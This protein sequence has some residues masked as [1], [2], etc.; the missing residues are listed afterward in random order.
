MPVCRYPSS[1]RGRGTA[2]PF[3]RPRGGGLQLCRIVL[4]DMWRLVYSAVE[5]VT[6]LANFAS[7]GASWRVLCLS[8]SGF[9]GSGVGASCLVAVRTSARGSH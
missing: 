1:P 3:Y 2:S 4:G 6:V 5:W 9:E 8:R 7:G